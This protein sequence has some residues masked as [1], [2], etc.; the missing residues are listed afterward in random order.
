MDDCGREPDGMRT[1]RHPSLSPSIAL[2]KICGNFYHGL[3]RINSCGIKRYVQFRGRRGGRNMYIGGLIIVTYVNFS[4]YENENSFLF[5]F[6][7]SNTYVLSLKAAV[8]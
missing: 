5:F 4:M 2:L 8:G 6:F 3:V 1:P 7:F